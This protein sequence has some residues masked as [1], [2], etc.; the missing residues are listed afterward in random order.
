MAD[1][2]SLIKRFISA[3]LK[4]DTAQVAAMLGELQAQGDGLASIEALVVPALERIGVDWEEGRLALSQVYMAG[5]I[6]EDAVAGLLPGNAAHR[7]EQ[8]RLAI[9]VVQDHHALGKRIV[10]SA[11]RAAGYDLLDYGHG[12][13]PQDL[14]EKARRDQVDVLLVSCLMVSAALRIRE[15]IAGL[16]RAG[17][18]TQVVVGGAPFRLDPLLWQEIGAQARGVNAT[19]AVGIVRRLSGG[20]P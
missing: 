4:L 14:V 13:H 6:C 3:L 18:H 15:V 9:A 8:P 12:L 20:R 11:L 10:S 1:H 7:P 19:D 17:S 2:A 16:E 5:K